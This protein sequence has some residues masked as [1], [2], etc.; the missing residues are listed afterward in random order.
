MATLNFIPGKLLIG[1]GLLLSMSSSDLHQHKHKP[2]LSIQTTVIKE[3]ALA[4]VSEA[5]SPL[6]STNNVEVKPQIDGTVVKILAKAGQPVKAGQVILVLDNVQ[7]NAALDSAKH[8]ARKD[9]L[10][11]ERY[12]YLYSQGAVSA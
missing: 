9:T 4:P 1:A 12:D 3:K 11:A 8:E 6:E 5:I 7:Q 10:N 2:F